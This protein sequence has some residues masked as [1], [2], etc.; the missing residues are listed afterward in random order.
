M[1][2]LMKITLEIPS[3]ACAR[4]SAEAPIRPQLLYP[5]A[6]VA[7][8]FRSVMQEASKAST[9]NVDGAEVLIDDDAG[10]TWKALMTE[11]PIGWT[12]LPTGEK[13]VLCGDCA[14]GWHNAAKAFMVPPPPPV[15]EEALVVA[16]DAPAAAPPAELNF[17]GSKPSPFKQNQG[18]GAQRNPSPFQQPAGTNVSGPQNIVYGKPGSPNNTSIKR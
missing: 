6:S 16:A 13:G 14:A 17:S 12:A 8:A 3:L 10:Q 9:E 18:F 11:R 2:R 7:P 5:L 1:L 4:C 15:I